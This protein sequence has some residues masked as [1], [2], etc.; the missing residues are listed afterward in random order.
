MIK[1]IEYFTMANIRH[2]EKLPN[3]LAAG[4]STGLPLLYRERIDI[5]L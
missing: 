2:L 5:V 3:T 4:Y 1:V